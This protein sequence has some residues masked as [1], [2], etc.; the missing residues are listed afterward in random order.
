[1][2]YTGLDPFSMQPVYV[3]KTPQEK[4][5]Q[6]VLLQYFKSENAPQ[7]RAALKAAGREDL[8]GFGK[9]CLVRP[10]ARYAAASGKASAKNGAKAL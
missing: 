8:I 6:R 7:V 10:D 9:E 4:A 3:A 2:F 5:M 1:M